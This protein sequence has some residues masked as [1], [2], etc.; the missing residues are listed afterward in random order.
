MTPIVRGTAAKLGLRK[1]HPLGA[2]RQ[3]YAIGVTF[4][5]ATSGT[6]W[7][8]EWAQNELGVTLAPWQRWTLERYMS[9]P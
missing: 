3:R 4:D 9:R 1:P 2:Y 8:I 5:E 7:L 6:D